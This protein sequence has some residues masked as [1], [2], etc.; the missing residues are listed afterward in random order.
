MNARASQRLGELGARL[1]TDSGAEWV[2]RAAW[3]VLAMALLVFVVRGGAQPEDPYLVGA[4]GRRELIPGLQEIAFTITT[5]E[6][7]MAEWCAMLAETDA[8][9][10]RGLMDQMDLGG[11]DGMV[12]RYT[13]PHTG[14]FWMKRTIIPLDIAYFDAE[15]RFV[16]AHA[17][18]PCPEEAGD[19][20]PSYPPAG[21]YLHAVEVAKNG[22]L[23]LGIGPGSTIAFPGGPCPQ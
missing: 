9:R 22:T 11:Y 20:C 21:P 18:E 1:E 3:T 8:E 7:A 14:G 12:F 10:A 4:D 23:P 6:G 13:E 5:A 17:M 2:R 16:S 19:S 15:G